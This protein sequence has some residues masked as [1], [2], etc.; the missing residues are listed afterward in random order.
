MEKMHIF[1]PI[2]DGEAKA[3]QALSWEKES[4]SF[5]ESIRNFSERLHVLR[6]EWE[7]E[8]E[9]NQAWLEYRGDP[10][11]SL[12]VEYV[13][14]EIEKIDESMKHLEELFDSV[15]KNALRDFV[16]FEKE[17]RDAREKGLLLEGDETRH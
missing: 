15:S 6:K 3:Q 12:S 17:M 10:I 2:S 13:R 7:E 4:E 16:A 14:G 9:R 1:P 11:D 8:L 5:L